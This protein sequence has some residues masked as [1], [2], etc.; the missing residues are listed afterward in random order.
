MEKL[1]EELKN[2]L[3]KVREELH[4]IAKQKTA[5]AER[6]A[7]LQA[8]ES[9]YQTRCESVSQK[10]K[11]VSVITDTLDLQVKV[12]QAMTKLEQDQ[13]AFAEKVVAEDVRLEK[14]QKELKAAQD[15]LAMDQVDAQKTRAALDNDIRKFREEKAAM[16][17]TIIREIAG[18]L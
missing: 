16:K 8:S 15:T 17:E 4:T 13:K 11:R 7:L 5:L 18:K 12:D 2:L 10:E 14:A 1:L 6:E 3:T 9:E